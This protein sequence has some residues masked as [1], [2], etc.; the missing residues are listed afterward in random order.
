M[1]ASDHALVASNLIKIRRFKGAMRL[2]RNR[3]SVNTPTRGIGFGKG[4]EG[5]GRGRKRKIRRGFKHVI[6]SGSR[7]TVQ[8]KGSGAL[9]CTLWCTLLGSC[10]IRELPMIMLTKRYTAMQRM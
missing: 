2:Y 6:M 10:G 7:A 1:A 3:L 4:E 9:W 5:G 8:D